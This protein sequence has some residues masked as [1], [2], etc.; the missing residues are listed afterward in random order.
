MKGLFKGMSCLTQQE[1]VA[2]LKEDL[3][4]TARYEVESHLLDCPL[5]NAAV[6]AYANNYENAEAELEADLADL[7]QK[8][9]LSVSNSAVSTSPYLTFNRV[10]ALIVILLT[11]AAT[12]M[13]Y[14][15]TRQGKWFAD[16]FEP[17]PTRQLTLRGEAETVPDALKTAM[18]FYKKE[19]FV[20][21][22]PHFEEYLSLNKGDFEAMYYA[23]IAELASQQYAEAIDHL[24]R[25][26]INDP[27]LYEAANWYLALAYLQINE[28][29]EAKRI[30]KALSERPKHDYQEEATALYKQLTQ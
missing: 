10:M 5:C 23:G 11:I 24:H 27:D 9:P 30:L 29:T 22:I 15:H 12:F 4:D 8:D 17:A 18:T 28:G 3:S 26:S 25:V 20:K 6:E 13:Y 14:Q 7:T 1:I 21:S 16:F 19:Q 2:Y